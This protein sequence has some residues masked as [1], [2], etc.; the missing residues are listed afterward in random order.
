MIFKKKQ[1]PYGIGISIILIIVAFIPFFISSKYY[2]FLTTILT[3]LLVFNILYERY[4]VKEHFLKIKK[5]FFYKRYNI[6]YI[7]QMNMAQSIEGERMI[8][9]IYN[10]EVVEKVKPIEEREFIITLMRINP[11]IKLNNSNHLKDLAKGAKLVNINENLNNIQ[12]KVD[13][14]AR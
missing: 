11:R 4:E 9:I 3:L 5:G 1:S 6:F 8:E 13:K 10:G 12:N 2:L 14:I 7:T